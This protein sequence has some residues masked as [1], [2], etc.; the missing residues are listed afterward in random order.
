MKEL[1]GGRE[2]HGKSPVTYFQAIVDIVEVDDKTF[3]KTVDILEDRA[4]RHEACRRDC[5]QLTGYEG[6]G[7]ISEVAF[8]EVGVDMVGVFVLNVDACVLDGPVGIVELRADDAYLGLLAYPEHGLK[9]VGAYHFGVVVEEQEVVSPCLACPKVHELGEV[10]LVLP[11]DESDSGVA[12]G[13]AF[14]IREGF[15]GAAVVLDDDNLEVLVA[16]LVEYRAYAGVEHGRIVLV[17]DDDGDQGLAHDVVRHTEPVLKAGWRDR[18]LYRLACKVSLD[19]V[20]ACRIRIRLAA[21]GCRRSRAC[22]DPPMVEDLGDMVDLGPLFD[23]LQYQVVVLGAVEAGIVDGQL[24]EDALPDHE[25]VADVVVL[26]EHEEAVV[27]L[28]VGVAV[29]PVGEQLVLV[30]VQEVEGGVFVEREGVLEERV[31]LKGVVVVEEG[32]VLPPCLLD[33][34]KGVL[35]D[36]FVRSEPDLADARVGS[37]AFCDRLSQ[38]RVLGVAVHQDKLE[39]LVGLGRDAFHHVV[40]VGQRRLV[41]GDDDA[42]QGG[43]GQLRRPLPLLRLLGGAVLLEPLRVC[44][45]LACVKG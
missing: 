45:V 40:E 19:C 34:C 38:C 26:P 12:F 22:A 4:L 14:I 2:Y 25:E 20:D 8:V 13:E 23:R 27:R 39:A 41:E 33:A 17:G 6:C 10:E 35:R 21:T 9:P 42:Y 18:S 3:I 43:I 30:A 11:G 7:E 1:D 36:T 32:D 31:G 28:E 15:L 29:A 37:V 24:V 16:A 5:A 44:G